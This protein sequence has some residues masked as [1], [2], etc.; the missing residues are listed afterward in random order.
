MAPVKTSHLFAALLLILC[1]LPVVYSFASYLLSNVGCMTD[2]S[3]DEVIMNNQVVDAEDSDRPKV[4]IVLSK[5]EG[6]DKF[7]DKMET[8]DK[9]TKIWLKPNSEELELNIQ[10]WV[11]NLKDLQFVMETTP[12]AAFLNG[13]CEDNKRIAGRGED[14]VALRIQA[15]TT[16][17]VQVWAGWATGHE[18]VRLTYPLEFIPATSNGGGGGA[19][20]GANENVKEPAE[21]QQDVKRQQIEERVQPPEQQSQPKKEEDEQND[22]TEKWAQKMKMYENAEEAK[23]RID[24]IKRQEEKEEERNLKQR[25]Q[26]KNDHRKDKEGHRGRDR[27]SNKIKGRREIEKVEQRRGGA[28]KRPPQ[29][30]KD[31]D[32]KEVPHR[33]RASHYAE[34]IKEK[35]QKIAQKIMSSRDSVSESEDSEGGILLDTTWFIYGLSILVVGTFAVIKRC[36]YASRKGD[37]KGRRD[38]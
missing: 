31:S 20:A 27:N 18:K 9:I 3:T 23:E 35:Q 34:R 5:G 19:D 6:Q 22:S 38:L 16:S 4:H 36:L 14:S 12:G 25:S 37:G 33:G 24:E 11:D 29:L 2:L 15:T 10:M 1:H 8:V 28:A 13:Q 7:I 21:E 30:E 32:H 17:S 26:D